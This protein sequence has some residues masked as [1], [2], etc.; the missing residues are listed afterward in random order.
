LRRE[1]LQTNDGGEL[2]LDWYQ[3]DNPEDTPI[4]VV[5]AGLV[6]KRREV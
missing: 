2:V 5:L 6:G 3:H 4:V 1:T